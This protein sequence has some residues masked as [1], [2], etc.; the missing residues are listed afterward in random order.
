MRLMSLMI[1]EMLANLQ[2]EFIV[3]STDP[4]ASIRRQGV[5]ELFRG[6]R[7]AGQ[8]RTQPV[9]GSRPEA[10]PDQ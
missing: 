3:S 7:F 4:F 1:L 2:R 6:K 10:L 8:P 9:G 5:D